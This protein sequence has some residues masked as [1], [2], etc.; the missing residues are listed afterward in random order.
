MDND[1][2]MQSLGSEEGK[3]ARRAYVASL[4]AFAL[5]PAVARAGGVPPAS[6]HA[7]RILSDRV[8]PPALVKAEDVRWASD[9][10][11]YLAL[12]TDGTVEVPI[13]QDKT[14]PR[15]MIPGKAR[16]GFWFNSKLAVSAEYLVVAGPMFGLTWRTLTQPSRREEYFDCIS[17]VDVQGDRLLVMG[18]RRDEKGDFAP[19]GAIAWM[20]SLSKQLADLRPILYDSA[21]AHAPHLD[22]CSTFGMGA[23]RFLADGS[24]LIVPGVQ[25]GAHLY[26]SRERLVR[27]WDTVALG[28]DSDC[29]SLSRPEFERLGVDI[30]QRVAWLNRRHTLD[31][32]LP[33]PSGPGLIVRRAS[34]DRT[35]WSLVVLGKTVETV[36]IPFS[37]PSRDGHLKA[38]IRGNK[39]VFLM[40]DHGK[41]RP[42]IEPPRLVV[43]EVPEK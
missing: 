33:L 10:S 11:V 22:A 37:I 8:L 3:L 9:T 42:V 34:G 31:D 29:A 36:T 7:L 21:G 28:L 4:L 18:A 26:D 1:D 25:P 38:D 15:E 43:A 13:I 17:D 5:N 19:D 32:I 16:A 14:E 24:F 6:P 12:M 41:H 27:T 23:V 40:Y 20:G 35:G 30:E 2:M 39:V